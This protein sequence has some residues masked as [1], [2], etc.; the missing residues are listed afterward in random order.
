MNSF[1]DL[2]KSRGLISKMLEKETDG[3][4]I[5]FDFLVDYLSRGK[6]MITL[7][8]S[9]PAKVKR[10]YHFDMDF[11]LD[12]HMDTIENVISAIGFPSIFSKTLK[13]HIL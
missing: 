3:E 8:F 11:F 12:K 6:P 5:D 1:D 10:K 4:I 2:Q 9:V 7:V 13:Y